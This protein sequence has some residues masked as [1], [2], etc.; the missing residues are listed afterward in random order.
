MN[1]IL[2]QIGAGHDDKLAKWETNIQEHFEKIKSHQLTLA[3]LS[4]RK[5]MLEQ[6]NQLK[7]LEKCKVNMKL[8]EETIQGIK[9]NRPPG[10]SIVL[11]NFDLMVHAAD[12]TS[13]NQNKDHH[14]CNHNAVLDRINPTEG[15][16]APPRQDLKDTPNSTFIPNLEEQAALVN[17]MVILISRVL[18]ENFKEFEPFKSVVP[19]H[20]QHKYSNEMKKKSEKACI[21]VF[22]DLEG[23]G[24]WGG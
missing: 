11:D 4:S 14:W 7:E 6:G 2:D 12:M 8:C 17:D 16:S 23:R 22:K 21:L 13:E 9:N 10:Y 3:S 24:E 1:K 5:M 20:I 15:D 18:V 19:A